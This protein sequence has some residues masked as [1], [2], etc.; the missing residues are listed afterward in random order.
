[1]YRVIVPMHCGNWPYPPLCGRLLRRSLYIITKRRS[2]FREVRY[3]SVKTREKI[4]WKLLSEN[5]IIYTPQRAVENCSDL[6]T[7]YV[8]TYIYIGIVLYNK[9]IYTYWHAREVR[10]PAINNNTY[11]IICVS[12][13]AWLKTH[14]NVLFPPPLHQ[15]ARTAATIRVLSVSARPRR[16]P[17]SVAAVAVVAAVNLP[18]SMINVGHI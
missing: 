6:Q 13:I 3:I 8:Y 17:V 11:Y 5:I 12:D 18:V 2:C 10:T 15:P 16:R 1:M 7:T 9:I 14:K 4:H